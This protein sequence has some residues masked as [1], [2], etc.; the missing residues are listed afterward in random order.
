MEAACAAAGLLCLRNSSFQRSSAR[1]CLLDVFHI[2]T[3]FMLIIC[4]IFLSIN[5]QGL[6]NKVK[7]TE[8]SYIFSIGTRK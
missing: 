6:A 4:S 1:K 5:Y 2:T 8:F 7:C 3:M